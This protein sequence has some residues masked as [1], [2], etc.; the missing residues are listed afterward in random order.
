MILTGCSAASMAQESTF[1]SAYENGKE[2]E[3]VDIYTSASSVIIRT[4][5]E[6]GRTINMYL[7]DRNENKS[8]SFDGATMIQ[9]RYGTAMTAAQLHVGDIA[10]ITYNSELERL[11]RV[12]LSEE[13]WKYEGI[14]KYNL[15]AG[16]GSAT[17]GEESYS[18]GNG[19]L[20]FSDGKAIEL[21]Q[22]IHQDVLSFQGKGHSIMSISV[23]RGHGYLDLDNE[24]AV[25]GGWIEIGQAVIAQIVPDMLLTVP[26]GSYTVRLTASGIEETREITIERN[27]ETVL[28]LGDIEV[29]V[30]EKGIVTFE[31]S[32]SDAMVYVDDAQIETV[33]PVRL[34]LGLHQIT[35]KADG[36]EDF[37]RYFKVEEEKTTVRVSME[38]EATVS[39]NNSDSQAK[40]ENRGRVTISAPKDVEVYQD[41]LY[42]GIAPVTYDKTVGEH[43]I[44]LR[45]TGYVTRSYTIVIEDDDQDVTYAF[46]DLDDEATNTSSLSTVSGNTVS[47]NKTETDQTQN[48]DSTVSGNTVSGNK[49]L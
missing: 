46:P 10:E 45:K 3:P 38:E 32:P 30:P 33:Y 47:G 7:V 20:I 37:S 23:D 25:L 15:N 17:I 39:G 18:I 26:E 43:T 41:N 36:Y 49:S 14:E 6:A 48:G 8:L 4:V 13:A 27:R 42:M 28:D 9:D 1:E 2:D 22:I 5:D 24:E 34:A 16:N 44:T 29:K 40:E 19:V 35:V 12:T 21:S 11:G 31:I